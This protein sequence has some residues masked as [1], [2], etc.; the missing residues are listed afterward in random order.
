M[1]LPPVEEIRRRALELI[2]PLKAP[3]PDG[4]P[5][6]FYKHYWDIVGEAGG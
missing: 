6:L 1:S 4:M 3:G 2:H 5:C